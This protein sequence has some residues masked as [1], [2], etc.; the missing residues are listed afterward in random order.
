MFGCEIGVDLGT[1]NVMAFVKGRGVVLNEPSVV[2][3]DT[4]SNQPLAFGHEAY[5]MI[6]RTPANLRAIRPLRD[7]VI[8]DYDLTMQMMRHFLRK[9]VRFRLT[10]PRVMVG[11]PSSATAVE[12][13]AVQD[14]IR[15]ACA[16]DV[17]LIEEPVAAALGAGIDITKPRGSIVVDIGGGTTDVAALSL[18]GIVI[19]EAVRVAGD[20]VDEGIVRFLRNEYQMMIGER[21]AEDIKINVGTV[22]LGSRSTEMTV[23]GRDLMTGLPKTVTVTSEQIMPA[24]VDQ[25]NL[26]I[27]LI[28]R[29]LEKT[30]PEVSA[31]IMNEGII[32]TGG[33]ALINGIDQLITKETGI[34]AVI[35]ENPLQCVALGTGRALD[36]LSK[37]GKYLVK[38]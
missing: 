35:A 18:G 26:V 23:C 20:K 22:S 9:I 14:A 7:G 33:G 4:D 15:E 11:V 38:H 25:V 32:L 27:D 8:S 36:G 30:P 3:I 6:G 1:A 19:S 2:A 37:I 24:M 29:V 17:Y 13:R 10:K 21:T 16:R 12:Q 34:T 31:D 5:R 28:K